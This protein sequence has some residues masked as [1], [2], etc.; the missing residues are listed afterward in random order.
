MSDELIERVK[1]LYLE[2]K[3]DAELD[4]TPDALLADF[5]MTSVEMIEFL[6]ELED[7]LGVRVDPEEIIPLKTAG[8]LL[9]LVQSRLP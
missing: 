6:S 1:A 9:A 7:Q 2:V 8:E 5:E 3:P 4:I